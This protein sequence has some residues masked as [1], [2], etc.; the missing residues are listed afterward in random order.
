MKYI[1]TLVIAFAYLPVWGQSDT[2]RLTEKVY[3]AR[4]FRRIADSMRMTAEEIS[5][6]PV[7]FPVKRAV[8][9]SAFGMR[10]HPIHKVRTGDVYTL[11]RNNSY[12]TNFGGTSAAAP[13]VAGIAALMLS[14]NPNL[15]QSAVAD[16]IK[17]SGN[18]YL[19]SSDECGRGL[20]DA[21]KALTLAAGLSQPSLSQSGYYWSEGS[22]PVRVWIG[23]PQTNV[24]YEWQSNYS[25]WMGRALGYPY[26]TAYD[27]FPRGSGTA[28]VWVKVRARVGTS[29]NY[30]YSNWSNTVNVSCSFNDYKGAK[31]KTL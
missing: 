21:H 8:I 10:R 16:F 27:I 14:V 17:R 5:G 23:S 30:I 20:V 29:P 3:S 26:N 22:D 15:T 19:G 11:D 31:D 28:D 25:G 4:E 9:S 1:L 18:L 24:D 13:Q 12:R 7:I 6:Y 2:D